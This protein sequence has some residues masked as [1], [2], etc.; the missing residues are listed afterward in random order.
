[1]KMM[2]RFLSIMMLG[3]VFLAPFSMSIV[4]AA[5]PQTVVL[6]VPGMTCGLCPITIS[7]ALENV[8]GVIEARS[9]YESKSAT[10][11]FDPTKTD[12]AA[13]TAATA[14]AGY[15]STPREP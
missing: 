13:L 14:T 11:V 5:E 1:M 3:L 7:K 6:D 15:P 9:D 12:V 10:V 4:Q 2:R 8:P